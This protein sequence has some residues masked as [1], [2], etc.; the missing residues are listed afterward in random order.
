MSSHS[1]DTTRSEK[2]TFVDASLGRVH[3]DAVS[4]NLSK[5]NTWRQARPP[6][7]T[8]GTSTQGVQAAIIQLWEGTV[9]SRDEQF[10]DVR[11]SDKTGEGPDHAARIDLQWVPEQDIDL[12]RP[13]AVFYLSLFRATSGGTIRNSQE[14]RF[15]RV[16][17]WSETQIERAQK[18]SDELFP[19]FASQAL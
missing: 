5:G 1:V 2:S 4:I 8:I 7:D 14:L 18:Y 3:S 12:V 11:L 13:G 10:M 6:S 15:R 9:L 19:E 17:N 16:P